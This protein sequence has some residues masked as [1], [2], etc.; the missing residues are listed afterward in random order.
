MQKIP[1]ILDMEPPKVN[2]YSLESSIAEKLEAVIHNGYLNS[3]YKDFYDIYVLST[4][5]T[6]S[7]DTL[8]NAVI[9]TFENRKTPMTMDSA[10]FGDEFLN[11]P[12][13][14][15][16]WK[17]FLKKKKALI[18]VPMD[19]AMAHIKLFVRPLDRLI[20]P[21]D[22]RYPIPYSQ[23]PSCLTGS[24]P[25]APPDTPPHSTSD[26]APTSLPP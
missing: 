20:I 19:E 9:E 21:F 3:R 7:F 22:D 16:R 11:D 26:T 24:P 6:F 10:A 17:A 2:A 13:H 4:K 1:V 12:M 25:V 14:Q 5:Y 8:K 15:T 23:V 18:Q